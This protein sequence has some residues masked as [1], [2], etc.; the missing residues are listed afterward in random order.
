MREEASCPSDRLL[1]KG[2]SPVVQGISLSDMRGEVSCSSD[3]LLLLGMRSAVQAISF[4]YEG[5]G[6]L[7]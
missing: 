6:Q 7:F 5:R 2:E 4:L 1:I 3:R